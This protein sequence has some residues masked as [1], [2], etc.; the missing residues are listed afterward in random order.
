M[1]KAGPKGELVELSPTERSSADSAPKNF[2]A[3]LKEQLEIKRAS[4]EALAFYKRM[5]AALSKVS[6]AHD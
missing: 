4:T 6:A 5:D 1:G 3:M 2:A